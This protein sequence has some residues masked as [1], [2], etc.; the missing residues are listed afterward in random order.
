[1]DFQSCLIIT[2]HSSNLLGSVH[3][4][5]LEEAFSIVLLNRRLLLHEVPDVVQQVKLLLILRLQL[6]RLVLVQVHHK[7]VVGP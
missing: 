1:M 2:V 4:G 3:R 6:R 7:L 5:E